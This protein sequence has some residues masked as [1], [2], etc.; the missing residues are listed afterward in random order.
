[1]HETLHAF[2][3]S[4]SMRQC[5]SRPLEGNEDDISLFKPV[6][7]RVQKFKIQIPSSGP[8]VPDWK[9]NLIKSITTKSLHN[10]PFRKWSLFRIQPLKRILF[11]KL[12]RSFHYLRISIL[13]MF[14]DSR[15]L[16]F[17][18]EFFEFYVP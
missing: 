7:V 11:V 17:M 14:I 4:H 15:R 3:T 1:M 12:F 16:N 2:N 5:I 8:D 9:P 6:L 18:A 10:V 13:F